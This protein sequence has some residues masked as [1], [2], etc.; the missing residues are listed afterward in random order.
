MLKVQV[1][2]I[3]EQG[4]TY[5]TNNCV[6]SYEWQATQDLEESKNLYCFYIDNNQALL[7]PKHAVNEADQHEEFF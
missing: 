7:V 5:Q 3:S 1:G 6:Q 4:L 2:A